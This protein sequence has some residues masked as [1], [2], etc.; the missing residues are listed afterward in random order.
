MTHTH[1]T[2]FAA[3]SAAVIGLLAGILG[4]TAAL[5]ADDFWVIPNAFQLAEG[6]TLELRGQTSSLFPTS[7]AAVAIDRLADARIIGAAG[8]APL[9]ERS[10]SGT[11]LLIRHPVSTTGQHIVALALVPRSVRETP[12]SF[13]RYM[14]LEGAP[15]AVTRYE[16]EGHLAPASSR[17]SLTRRY[18]KYAKTFVEVGRGGPRAFERIAGHPLEF[19]PLR[20]PASLRIG[21]TLSVRVLLLGKPLVG[22]HVHAGAIAWNG[23]R[24]LADTGA[25]RRSAMGDRSLTTD[26]AGTIRVPVDRPGMWNVRGIQILPAAAGSGS[27]WDVH[28]ATM[29]FGAGMDTRSGSPAAG[30]TSDSAAVAAVVHRYDAALASGDS[31]TALALLAPDA[32]VLES[33]GME[34]R[35]EYRSHHLPADMA[36]A[37]AV[38]GVSSPVHVVIE[39]NAAWASSTSV[40][41][42]EYRGKAVNSAGSELMVLTRGADGAWR[43]RAIHWSSRARRQP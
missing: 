26:A 3:R 15:E 33:G 34:S 29:V 25:A 24:T 39:G 19:I 4:S 36:Y 11:S 43:I 14:M 9:G 8:D 22:A 6:S 12:A 35:A 20:D 18:A 42:G 41:Q 31:A 28:W 10:V 27:D 37:R 38:K 17:D 23:E 5:S 16:R 21:D 2:R 7:K 32:V 40:S 1:R 30:S 13:R